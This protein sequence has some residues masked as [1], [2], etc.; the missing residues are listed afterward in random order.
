MPPDE[1]DD[2]GIFTDAPRPKSVPQHVVDRQAHTRT[3]RARGRL[4]S[5]V[6]SSA[7]AG[8]Q[9]L[10]SERNPGGNRLGPGRWSGEVF[11]F[12]DWVKRRREYGGGGGDVT[13]EFLDLRE[14]ALV[15]VSEALARRALPWQAQLCPR[16]LQDLDIIRVKVSPSKA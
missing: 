4:T 5:P 13:V 14:A 9:N 12:G 7:P 6:L 10:R 3:A 8:G 15:G 16:A 1:W 2:T 11:G